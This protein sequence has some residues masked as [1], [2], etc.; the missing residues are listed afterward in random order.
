MQSA[1]GDIEGALEDESSALHQACTLAD[2]PP[3]ELEGGVA[4]LLQDAVA[5]ALNNSSGASAAAAEEGG[6]GELGSQA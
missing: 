5:A 2:C 4:R 3:E 6:G 1:E